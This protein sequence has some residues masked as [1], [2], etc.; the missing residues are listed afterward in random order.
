MQVITLLILPIAI[1]LAG[2]LF[3]GHRITLKEVLIQLTISIFLVILGVAICNN[4]NRV[5]TEMHSGTIVGKSRE[6]VMCSHSY[7]CHC[8][9]I[10]KTTHCDT[11][12]MHLYDV[13]WAVKT[14]ID[15]GF[16]IN[17]EDLQGLIQP[18]RWTKI[19]KGEPY[20]SSAT[21][22]NYIKA[23]PDSLFSTKYKDSKYKIPSYPQIYDYYK[24]DRL[25]S[26][27]IKL[28]DLKKLNFKLSKANSE[29]W[30]AV[31]ANLIIV[32]TKQPED[33]VHYLKAKWV[34][35]KINDIVVVMSVEDR[36]DKPKWVEVIS[37]EK[38]QST[39]T[40]LKDIAF[41]T[42]VSD[43][44][45][46]IDKAK[47]CIIDNYVLRDTEDFSYLKESTHLKPWEYILLFVLNAI[48][49]IG[50]T[51]YMWKNDI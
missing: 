44:G 12:Y 26:E 23:S 39:P 5:D 38:S 1:A 19:Y 3:A 46:F 47:N 45:A 20:S 21:Y 10:G 13:D 22:T 50:I 14:D 36:Q 25:I 16:C 41:D 33:Y 17:R 7:P 18:K 24:V 48:L 27:E 8:R 37:W 15:S 43:L 42:N 28:K 32:I 49:S 51:V 6:V 2:Y 9:K 40:L 30:K 35:A 11:C 31:K 34:G 4:A 29:V